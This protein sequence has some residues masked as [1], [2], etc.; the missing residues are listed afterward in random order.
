LSSCGLSAVLAGVFGGELAVLA[1]IFG[2][3]RNDGPK[4]AR[5]LPP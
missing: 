2:G 4:L 5:A 3:K 1:G